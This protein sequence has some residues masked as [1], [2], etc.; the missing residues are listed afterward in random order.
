M[1]IRFRYEVRWYAFNLTE[2]KSRKFFTKIG[3]SIYAAYL[4]AYEDAVVKI[5]EL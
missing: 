1:E 5:Y 3:A 2:R 4:E